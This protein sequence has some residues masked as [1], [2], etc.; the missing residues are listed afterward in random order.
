M[1]I[2]KSFY[3]IEMKY[4]RKI[5]IFFEIITVFMTKNVFFVTKSV[6]NE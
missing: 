5:N 6:K 4:V 1:F 2:L 3:Q